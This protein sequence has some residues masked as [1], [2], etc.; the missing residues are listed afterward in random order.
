[1][2]R[3]AQMPPS[4]YMFGVLNLQEFERQ[5]DNLNAAKDVY[6]LSTD[7]LAFWALLI[8]VVMCDAT[9]S[10]IDNTRKLL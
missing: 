4:D 2:Q 8:K 7:D 10:S 5:L 9:M 3:Q 1:M 6:H